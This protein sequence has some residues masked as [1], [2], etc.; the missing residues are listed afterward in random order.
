MSADFVFIKLV[1]LTLGFCSILH[2][3][4]AVA[5][6][7]NCATCNADGSQ[8]TRCFQVA[9]DDQQFGIVPGGAGACDRCARDC[10]DCSKSG[11]GKCDTCRPGFGP[12]KDNPS[13]CGSCPLNCLK[14]DKLGEAKCE[15][16]KIGYVHHKY[17]GL[18]YRCSTGC[19]NCDVRGPDQC[20]RCLPGY[21][22]ADYFW[23]SKCSTNCATCS[24]AGGGKCDECLPGYGPAKLDPHMCGECPAHC[25]SCKKREDQC[26]ECESSYQFNDAG[27]K[28]IVQG[29]MDLSILEGQVL[30]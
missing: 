11:A 14:C 6:K 17:T 1:L 24:K 27:S 16:C 4:G 29:S 28:C 5:C 7:A 30:C 22:I 18:C 12:S 21:G 20:D 3:S 9:A 25:K 15:Q 8:C 13:H 26:D 10:K 23:C 19:E 2:L